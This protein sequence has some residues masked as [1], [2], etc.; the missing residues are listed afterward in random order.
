MRRPWVPIALV[1]VALVIVCATWT[2]LDRRP[3][4]WDHA[5]HLERAVQCARDLGAGDVTALLER[6]SFY[7]PLVICSAGALYRLWPSDV[8]AA[9][10]VT[11]LFLGLGMLA[12]FLLGRRTGGET[13]GVVAAILFGTAPFVVFLALRFQLD[14]P[15]AAMVAFALW[16]LVG[17]DGF[18]RRG[19]ALLAGVL[20]GLG[21]LTKPSFVVYVLPAVLVSLRHCRRPGAVVNLVL[22][23]VAAL[24]VALPWYGPRA[25]GMMAQVGARSGKQA[26]ESG[27]PDPFTWAGLSFYPTWITPQ[28]GIVAV[29]LLLIGLVVAARRGQGLL[30]VSVIVPFVLWTLIQ[31]KNLRYT[32]PILPAA[33][34]VASM[35]FASLGPRLR[36]ITIIPLT[37]LALLQV[38]GTAFGVPP[39]PTL[40]FGAPWLLAD[41]PRSDDWKQRE[42]LAVL[43]RE[44][45]GEPVT[46]SVVP[47]DSHFSVSNFRYYAVRDGLPFRW[48]RAW[49]ET[50]LGI[51]FMVLKTGDQG[52]SWTAEK[53]RR[54]AER[55]AKDHHLA[56]VF[57][58]IAEVP[59]PDGS[60]AMIRA[61]RVPP[62]E[63]SASALADAVRG[64]VLKAIPQFARDVEDLVVTVD[65]GGDIVRGQIRSITIAARAATIGELKRPTAGVLRVRDFR[66]VAHDVL[67]N[68]GSAMDGRLDVLDARKIVVE[69]ARITSEDLAA[70]VGTVKRFRR[71]T[72]ALEHGAARVMLRQTGPD[73]SARIRILPA[74]DRP[75]VIEAGEVRVGGVPL[76]DALVHWVIRNYDPTP[77]LA[78]RMPVPVGIGDVTITPEAIAIRSGKEAARR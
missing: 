42:L 29:V 25:F 77:R 72:L 75:F 50:P 19:F 15:L 32:A 3:P 67:V 11:W 66:I 59:L 78:A 45:R 38:S 52:P 56:R 63:A 10:I 65:D 51:D 39:A 40:L 26:A 54:I 27:H 21:M 1:F 35:A 64:V 74:A 73:V 18:T 57:S 14:L 62:S 12:T 61:R 9:Q 44:A 58:V 24:I 43:A 20:C 76:P 36:R 48:T 46:V 71:A 47:N 60:T 8:A 7:P 23:M 49:D 6:S 5:N 41:W 4:E 55:L 68:P 70:Y 31:N 2:A 22:A 13:T 30:L 16:A 53:P 33:A 69:Q 37:L 17:S 34:V 28:L